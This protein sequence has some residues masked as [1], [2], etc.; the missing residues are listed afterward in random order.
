MDRVGQ[1]REAISARRLAACLALLASIAA[2]LIATE[3]FPYHSLNHDEAVYL[4]QAAMLLEGQLVLDPPMAE[5][6]RPWFFVADNGHL[7]P[8]YTPVTA[9][10]FA[11]GVAIGLPRLAL[12]AIAAGTIAALYATVAEVFD[13]RTGLVAAVLLLS[14]PLFLIHSGVF[15]PYL[16]TMG[17]N[18]VFAWAYLRGDRTGEQRWAILAGI[19]IG[20]A[21]FARPYTAVLFAVPFICHAL[22]RC[23][24]FERPVLTHHFTTAALGLGG[25]GI[26]LGYNAFMTGDPLTFPYQAFAPADDLGFGR[27]ELLGYERV[28]TIDLAVRAMVANLSTF[29]NRWIVAA[30][31][32]ALVAVAG[33]ATLLV[34]QKK[35]LRSRVLVI[36]GLGLTIPIGELYFWGTVNVLGDLSVPRDGLIGV[37]GPYYHFGLLV[38]TTALGAYALVQGGITVTRMWENRQRAG[39]IAFAVV[40][41]GTLVVGALLGGGAIADPVATN[42]EV[43]ATYEEAYEPI[44]SREFDDALVTVPPVHGEWLNHP[45]QYLRNDIDYDGSVLYALNTRELALAETFSERQLYRYVYRGQWAPGSA[46]PVAPRLQPIERVAGERVRVT[47]TATVPAWTERVSIALESGPERTYVSVDSPG[48]EL[49]LDLEVTNSTVSISSP[50]RFEPTTV[51]LGDSRTI[52]MEIFVDSGGLN[53]FSYEISVPVERTAGGV[54]AITPTLSVCRQ[55]GPCGIGSAYVPGEHQPGVGLRTSLT[56][57]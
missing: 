1:F 23:R 36:V 47:T 13:R 57:Q 7:Y 43:T 33:L 19:A 45:F 44:E 14:S 32:G 46:P 24:T 38:P 17:L 54:R 48:E 10:L 16:P 21:F 9:I 40:L 25:V 35:K 52:E 15:L 28:Y 26:A 20:A 2:W 34:R 30:P 29:V 31:L 5:V 39:Q 3:L 4:Q 8:K 12:A 37:L 56:S 50:G 27:R 55:A 22:W 42:A 18:L 41:G 11:P 51:A 6:F 49:P 53:T